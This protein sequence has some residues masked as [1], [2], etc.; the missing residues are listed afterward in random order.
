MTTLIVTSALSYGGR[1]WLNSFRCL[2][3][4]SGITA[5]WRPLDAVGSRPWAI[6]GLN[7]QQGWQFISWQHAHYVCTWVCSCLFVFVDS[8]IPAVCTFKGSVCVYGTGMETESFWRVQSSVNS[9]TWLKICKVQPRNR[10]GYSP[11]AC[12]MGKTLPSLSD[13]KETDFMSRIKW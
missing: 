11:L 9:K 12:G 7:R 3:F 4:R 6:D 10:D 5:E 8:A 2:W 1:R 13:R